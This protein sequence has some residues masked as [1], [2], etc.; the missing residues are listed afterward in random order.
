MVSPRTDCLAKLL[1][2]YDSVMASV[3]R[4]KAIDVI[5]LNLYKVFYMVLCDILISKLERY[6]FEGYT[7]QWR[8][9]C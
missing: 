7:I 8:R 6:G 4:V 9:N 3:D 2:F 1:I 5:Y